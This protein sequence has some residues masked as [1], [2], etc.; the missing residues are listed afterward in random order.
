MLR[1]TIFLLK[2]K[3]CPL[4]ILHRVFKIVKPVAYGSVV[5]VALQAVLQEI[6]RH[7]HYIKSCLSCAK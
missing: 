4:T 7:A 6:L 2:H 5:A 3:G 1:S